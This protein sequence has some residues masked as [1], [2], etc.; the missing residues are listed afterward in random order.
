[1][2][3]T[4]S[5]T[6]E[7]LPPVI[8][9]SFKME[10]STDPNRRFYDDHGNYAYVEHIPGLGAASEHSTIVWWEK[11]T[12]KND[13]QMHP[14]SLLIF[15][16]LQGHVTEEMRGNYEKA[17]VKPC[18][19]PGGAGKW[20]NPPDQSPHHLLR[21]AF[22]KLQQK[23][24]HEK[25]KH[26]ITAYWS[27]PESAIVNAFKRCGVLGGDPDDIVSEQASQGFRAIDGRRQACASYRS[28]FSHWSSKNVRSEHDVLP[29]SREVRSLPTALDGQHWNIYGS[30]PARAAAEEK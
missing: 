1:M 2:Y 27:I 6:G 21:L 11:M 19:I 26:L 10:K 18:P 14:D 17:G 23:N 7:K 8:L 4:F 22:I 15:D 25:L 3:T 29:R 30:G 28:A 9:V 5:S 24:R 16:A 12:L 13:Y 20:L